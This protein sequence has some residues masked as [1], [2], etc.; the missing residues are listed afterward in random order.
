MSEKELLRLANPTNKAKTMHSILDLV[1]NETI[2]YTR[3]GSTFEY[4]VELENKITGVVATV[5][6][7]YVS[8]DKEKTEINTSEYE[9]Q[10]EYDSS[11]PKK[12]IQETFHSCEDNKVKTGY[13]KEYYVCKVCKKDWDTK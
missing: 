9:F 3:S 7:K 4:E 5:I 1:Q 10:L 13:S 2:N 8:G 12:M 6:L 11:I